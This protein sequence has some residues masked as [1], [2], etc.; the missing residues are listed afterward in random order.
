MLWAGGYAESDGSQG[1]ETALSK[2]NKTK[3]R[4]GFGFREKPAFLCAH[5]SPD[6]LAKQEHVGRRRVKVKARVCTGG[7]FLRLS[8]REEAQRD[9]SPQLKARSQRHFSLP[10]ENDINTIHM[11]LSPQHPPPGSRELFIPP[12]QRETASIRGPHSAPAP[13]GG[14]KRSPESRSGVC[15]CS[16]RPAPP[17]LLCFIGQI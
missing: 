4:P 10:G 17:P 7:V 16:P 11:F 6:R 5:S 9:R 12:R 3:P 13:R 1:R 2:K 14:G 8:L 15:F